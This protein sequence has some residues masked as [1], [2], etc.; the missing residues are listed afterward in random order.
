MHAQKSIESLGKPRL[1]ESGK[2][3]VDKNDEE[4]FAKA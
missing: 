4:N 1:H 2:R 3:R